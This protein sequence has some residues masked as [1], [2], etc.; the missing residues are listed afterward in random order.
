M[1]VGDGV[2]ISGLGY[3]AIGR[4]TATGT[5]NTATAQLDFISASLK[6]T[7]EVKVLEEINRR[8]GMSKSIAMSKS[9]GGDIEFYF[10]PEST[11][12]G[13][14]LQNAMGGS[15]T[16][17][18]IT[19]ETAGAAANS[20]IVHTFS[21][22]SIQDQSFPA[23]CINQRFG[24][25][26]GGKVFNYSGLRTNTISFSAEID[27]AL[28]C[29]INMIGF[30]ST[31]T[32]T[33]VESVLSLTSTASPLSFVQGRVSSEAVFASLTSSSFWHVQ[34][35]E[36]TLENS[37][38]GDT[39]SRRLGS[40]VLGVL[41]SG[42]ATGN[43]TIGLRFDTTQAFDSMIAHSTL[44][45]EFEFEGSLTMTGSIARP[46]ILFRFPKCKI[47]SAPEPEVSGPDNELTTEI[48]VVILHDDSSNTGNQMEAILTNQV[49]GYT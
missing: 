13:F 38:K 24:N 9:I 6:T 7:Q 41:P 42:V 46:G 12:C 21:L 17:A 33:D 23:M 11:A 40:D 10:Y 8:R 20:A 19:G 14:I 43:L 16:S 34:T 30:N 47:T 3:L 22:E 48:S 5:Y 29:T 18:T 4:E 27:D 26:T 45:F 31:N 35:M 1:A 15:I 39:E 25:S 2:L 37:L 36:F 49:T 32:G 28:K 44:A